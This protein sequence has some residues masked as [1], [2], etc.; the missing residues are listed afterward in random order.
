MSTKRQDPIRA[1]DFL[2]TEENHA[3]IVKEKARLAACHSGRGQGHVQR[4]L[5]PSPGHDAPQRS[6]AV[7]C[8]NGRQKR[9]HEEGA[10]KGAGRA[11][12]GETQL[13]SGLPGK[14]DQ[15]PMR[16]GIGT[17]CSFD[18]V[19]PETPGRSLTNFRHGLWC[20]DPKEP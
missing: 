20:S 8:H 13:W 18:L 12:H 16:S 10:L 4:D 6:R 3:E 15:K 17:P 2:S 19:V 14:P 5:C 11:K 9:Q 1:L 7:V